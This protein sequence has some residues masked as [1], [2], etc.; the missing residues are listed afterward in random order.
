M[1]YSPLLRRAALL[2]PLT[3]T[4]ACASLG[5]NV[6]SNFACRA[7]EGTCAPTSLID[8]AATGPQALE[9]KAATRPIP[10]PSDGVRRLRVV[11][12]PYRDAAGRDHEARIVHLT[13]PEPA[14]AGWR[15]PQGRRAVLGALAGAIAAARTSAVPAPDTPDQAS[16][17]P[18]P[19]LLFVP[20]QPN[21]A[22]PGADAPDPGGPGA[23]PPPRAPVPHPD[24]NEGE[25]P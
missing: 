11:L 2:A 21:P 1:S 6:E 16:P 19:E 23:F 18:L 13:L 25:R 7:P 17:T 10:I 3:L 22:I 24:H 15:A 8:A 4:A 20:P 5:G 12:A 14:G 9:A